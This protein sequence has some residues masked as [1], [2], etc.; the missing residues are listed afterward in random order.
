LDFME[1]IHLCI[2]GSHFGA[3]PTTSI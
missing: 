1:K 2:L 3:K